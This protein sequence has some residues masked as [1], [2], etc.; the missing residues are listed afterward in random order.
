MS[1][2]QVPNPEKGNNIPKHVQ[3]KQRKDDEKFTS[4]F[5]AIHENNILAAGK[6]LVAEP[7]LVRR[8]TDDQGQ[9]YQP[10][11]LCSSMGRTAILRKWL[12]SG[13]E[14][15]REVKAAINRVGV[16]ALN[17]SCREGH[18]DIARLLVSEGGAAV[19]QA[20][21]LGA[22]PRFIACQNGPADIVHWLVSEGG[23]AVN[24]ARQDGTTPLYIACQEGHADIV[25]WLVTEGGAVVNQAEQDGT[26]PLFI[27][28]ENGMVMLT[29]YVGW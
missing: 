18:A 28:C 23:A 3:K 7:Q 1:R 29:L 24:Q 16:D 6:L 26:T 21:E 25:R 5:Q 17:I 20:D 9:V 11:C 14:V 12:R 13:R 15:R 8:D 2:R 19:N 22:T 27:A 10:L 4:L